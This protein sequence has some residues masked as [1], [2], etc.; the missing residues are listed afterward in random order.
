MKANVMKKSLI[1]PIIL[2]ISVI[3]LYL[4]HIEPVSA[5]ETLKITQDQFE[6][7]DEP[8]V[9]D[10]TLLGTLPIN[11]P[12]EW[13]GETSGQWFRVKAPN[14]QIGWIHN[15]GLSRPTTKP[16]ST[17][18]P[19]SNTS[20]P[21]QMVTSQPKLQTTVSTLEKKNEQYKAQLNEKERRIAE[22][23][24]DIETLENKISDAAQ[25]LDD[26]EQ[27]RK[28][29]EMQTTEMQNEIAELNKTLEEKENALLTER[30]EITKLQTQL[31]NLQSQA[32]GTRDRDWFLLYA[33]SIPLNIL[34][35]FLLGFFWFR[36]S[37]RKDQK[38][39]FIQSA[40]QAEEEAA[41][42]DN[43]EQRP[44]HHR[45]ENVELISSPSPES[46]TQEPTTESEFN[47]LDIVMTSSLEEKTL[48]LEEELAQTEEESLVDEDVVIDLSDVLPAETTAD[49]AEHGEEKEIEIISQE[50]PEQEEPGK[51][52]EKTIKEPKE[53]YSPNTHDITDST[54]TT[55]SE[56]EAEV[57]LQPEPLE[58]MS[59]DEAQEILED[60]YENVELFEDDIEVIPEEITEFPEEITGDHICQ[61]LDALEAEDLKTSEEA[62]ELDEQF[63]EVL[64]ETSEVKQDTSLDELLEEGELAEEEIAEAEKVE[65]E[66]E[67]FE[68]LMEHSTQIIEP[69]EEQQFEDV[70]EPEPEQPIEE[71]HITPIEKQKDVKTISDLDL[72]SDI[73]ETPI[74]EAEAEKQQFTSIEPEEAQ[75]FEPEAEQLDAVL[76]AVGKTEKKTPETLEQDVQELLEEPVNKSISQAE[77]TSKGSVLHPSQ[78][79]AM[80]EQ[81]SPEL[82]EP[83]PILIEPEYE[84]EE[85]RLEEEETEITDLT[86]EQSSSPQQSKE[87]K[88]DIELIEVGEN[89]KNIIHILSKID[90]LAKTPQELVNATPCIIARG[91]READAKNFQVVMKKFGSSVRLIKKS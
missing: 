44:E 4:Q 86:P 13:T 50:L 80:R 1:I 51:T 29:N 47:E 40:G 20:R 71:E 23:T 68:M 17:R 33:V 28:M 91:A 38:E 22:L 8:R 69:E 74:E 46:T 19:R 12:V 52:T 34:G 59:H 14:G 3:G 72:I 58:P 77:N 26:T 9:A 39:V 83:S 84:A 79:K 65:I 27:L 49:Q 24:K 62:S 78:R 48:P 37:R 88:Y 11:T 57:E 60:D 89:K 7:R 64:G 53:E 54:E 6:F 56:E 15:S 81:V 76:G 35:L 2:C 32:T 41:I 42:A 73:P 55:I 90:G 31:K 61:E 30:V 75:I 5:A 18:R 85:P 10:E 21:S 25:M 66:G 36:N 43:L 63:M 45:E 16:T 70:I 82:L 87:P 67:T